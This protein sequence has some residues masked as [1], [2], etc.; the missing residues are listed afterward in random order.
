MARNKLI[1]YP[2]W[3]NEP[4]DTAEEHKTPVITQTAGVFHCV[5]SKLEGGWN[6]VMD[7]ILL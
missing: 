3:V 6:S 2:N 7:L 1:S 4:L 5:Q